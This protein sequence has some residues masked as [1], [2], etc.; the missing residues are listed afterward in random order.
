MGEVSV[1]LS[2][3]ALLSQLSINSSDKAGKPANISKDYIFESGICFILDTLQI[4]LP[5]PKSII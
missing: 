2:L 3:V 5:F 1:R 4:F